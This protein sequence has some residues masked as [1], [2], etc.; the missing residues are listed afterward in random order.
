MKEVID[1]MCYIAVGL[2]I[3]LQNVIRAIQ[4]YNPF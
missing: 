3:K 2:V 1:T 4:H